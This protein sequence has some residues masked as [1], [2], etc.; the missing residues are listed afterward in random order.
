M[1]YRCRQNPIA[2]DENVRDM[3]F[4]GYVIVF[5]VD[6]AQQCVEILGIYKNNLWKK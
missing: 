5:F 1:P 4:K 3:I 6:E 2:K